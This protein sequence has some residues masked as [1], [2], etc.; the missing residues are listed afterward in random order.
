MAWQEELASHDAHATPATP[1]ADE[2]ATT[3]PASGRSI[4]GHKL[5]EHIQRFRLLVLVF[6]A[7]VGSLDTRMR[8]PNTR[9]ARSR[10]TPARDIRLRPCRRS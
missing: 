10:G 8:W 6:V 3:L 9:S 4:I 2:K 5:R 1:A 7:V